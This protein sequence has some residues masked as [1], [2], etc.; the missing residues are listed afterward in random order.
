MSVGS[1]G[2][3]LGPITVTCA[4][5]VLPSPASVEVTALVTL[6]C[7]PAVV[8]VTITAKVHEAPAASVAPDSTTLFDPAAAVIVPPP[9]VPVNPLGV[10]TAK[11]AGRVSVKLMPL[12]DEL[13][14]G[15]DKLKVSEMLALSATL[16]DPKLFAIVGAFVAGG[17]PPPDDP[18]PQLTQNNRL[19]IIPANSDSPRNQ[20]PFA[21]PLI[22]TTPGYCSFSVLS[23][24]AKLGR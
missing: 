2:C 6:F 14:L 24:A 5:A 22:L 19:T 1:A 3:W 9:Q 8:P 7:G 11:P 16:V 17:V 15:F 12:K 21:L 10:D 4:E 20:L 13:G 18:P 23:S